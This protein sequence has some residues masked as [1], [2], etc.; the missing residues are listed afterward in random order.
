M[1][2]I[3]LKVYNMYMNLKNRKFRNVNLL[4]SLIFI[5]VAVFY[6]INEN[7]SP[8]AEKT[9]GSLVSVTSIS[10]GDTVTLKIGK[11]EEKVRLIGIDAPELAQKPWGDKS[12]EF[13]QSII[14]SSGW[15]VS[16]EY[17]IERRDKYGRLLAYLRTP[18]GN[19]INREILEN[20]Y[21]MLFTVPPNVKYV[22]ELTTAQYEARKKKLGIWSSD[23]GLKQKPVDYRRAH[24][25]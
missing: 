25:R 15:K 20:G 18:N 6:L 9:T 8:T 7:K 11:R 2:I 13:L 17:D 14:S 23:K 12:K 22:N 1:I 19:L 10:D 3:T 24:P 4:T 21:A 5:I 16:I